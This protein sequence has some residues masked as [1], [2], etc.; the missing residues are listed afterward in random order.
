MAAIDRKRLADT[1][2]MGR[3]CAQRVL[4]LLEQERQALAA[5][6]SQAIETLIP[7]KIQAFERWEQTEQQR[8][9]LLHEAGFTPDNAGMEKCL[10][11]LVAIP[12]FRSAWQK[13]LDLTVSCRRENENNGTIIEI[14]RRQ[15]N[16]ALAIL[17]GQPVRPTGYAASGNAQRNQDHRLLGEA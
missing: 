14:N 7:L 6:D 13:L 1:L 2:K 5:R 17:S 15:T 8:L 11:E 9:T 10:D 3:I 16:E 12:Q 4:S